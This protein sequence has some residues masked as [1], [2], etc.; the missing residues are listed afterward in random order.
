M[1]EKLAAEILAAYQ[2]TG[3]AIKKKEDN[4]QFNKVENILLLKEIIKVLKNIMKVEELKERVYIKEN[5][6]QIPNMKVEEV[7]K[8]QKIVKAR[9][10]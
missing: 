3:A 9:D 8:T 1:S 6:N 4:L 2:N 10:K 5:M 7:K